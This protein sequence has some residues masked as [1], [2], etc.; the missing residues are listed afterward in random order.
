MKFTFEKGL[1]GLMVTFL[2]LALTAHA[3][4]SEQPGN[5]TSAQA[6]DPNQQVE[7]TEMKE[8]PKFSE[9]DVDK[10]GV[11]TK[12]EVDNTWLAGDFTK[13]DINQDGYI[14]ESEYKQA[15]G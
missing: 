1:A 12:S 13:F 9:L 7:S 2:A 8:V 15:L 3:Q 4:Q 10:D 5:K 6:A 11:L 14:N